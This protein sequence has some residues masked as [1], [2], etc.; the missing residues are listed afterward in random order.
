V[1]EEEITSFRSLFRGSDLSHGVRE[2]NQ[3][4]H[5]KGPA[6]EQ[7][8]LNHLEG[9]KGLGI[10]PVNENGLSWF[11]AIDIDNHGERGYLIE[12]AEIASRISRH[13]LPLIL[14]RSRSGG[15]HLYCFVNDP[16]PAADM[17][18]FL[19]GC[20]VRLGCHDA[21][22]FP[23]QDVIA[24]DRLGN[25]IYLPYFG[26]ENSTL[27]AMD[28]LAA[29][30]TF[31]QFLQRVRF[32]DGQSLKP[33][34]QT[35]PEMPRISEQP[36]IVLARTA[37]PE[38]QVFPVGSRN[39]G[40]NRH[41]YIL[42]R[43]HGYTDTLIRDVAPYINEEKTAGH[44]LAPAE[45]E[46]IV[47]SVLKTPPGDPEPVWPKLHPVGYQGL[48]GSIVR[49]LDPY[50]ESDPL[51]I[52]IH[53]LTMFGNLIGRNP[54]FVVEATWHHTNLFAVMVGSTSIGR[55][56]TAS[57]Q[58]LRPLKEVDP[59]WP[60]HI[61]GGVGSGEAVIWNVRDPLHASRKKGQDD[62]GV[63]DKRLLILESE[64][65]NLLQVTKREGTTVSAILRQAWDKG[66]LFNSVKN[67]PA[68]ATDAHISMIGHI[69]M[70]ELRRH[71]DATEK[72]NGF[73]NRIL[74]LLVKRSKVLPEPQPVPRSIIDW[75]VRNL[76]I[77]AAFAGS[78][79]SMDRTKIARDLWFDVYPELTNEY[80]DGMLAA[81]TNRAAAQAVR[82]SMIFA[83]LDHSA[84]IDRP[85]LE[86]ALA[87]CRYA[88]DSVRY[89]FGDASGFPLADQLLRE[90]T[91]TANGLTRRDISNLLG[92]HRKAEEIGIALS[93][94]EQRGLATYET[95]QSG[96]GRPTERWFA[97]KPQAAPAPP[98]FEHDVVPE[99][100]GKQQALSEETM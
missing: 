20:I 18:A 27:Y 69:T 48:A 95:E 79:Q 89:I 86:A 41:L 54:R 87:I 96:N 31:S 6:T 13:Q 26:G 53:L 12:F 70:E 24:K 60:H 63:A 8:W 35:E 1:L 16:V 88:E 44:P 92:R 9:R 59:E 52:L 45:L 21:E 56:G 40:I 29:A 3:H 23:K 68:R 25:F 51:A 14:C 73:A 97:V 93:S 62:L 80:R 82:L 32:W 11:G 77:A 34:G 5:P 76:K 72:A 58:A 65:A 99:I 64:L 75:M 28:D 81:M 38:P 98:V 49:A 100:T 15:A 66:N 74:W 94:L 42:R 10:V 83:L 61:I 90:L 2:E 19:R 17:R 71:L 33:N 7:D 57:D 67:S 39:N 47:R 22:I 84:Q 91:R 43:R 4:S 36:A 30:Q 78:I 85:H 50:T 37:S 46:N 55:K